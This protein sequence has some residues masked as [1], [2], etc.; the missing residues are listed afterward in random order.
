MYSAKE[1]T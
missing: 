1:E